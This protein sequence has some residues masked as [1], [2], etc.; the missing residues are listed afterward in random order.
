MPPRKSRKP[1]RSNRPR[2]KIM[3][4]RKLGNMKPQSQTVLYNKISDK[5]MHFV[6]TLYGAQVLTGA[7][8]AAML[9]V[10]NFRVSDIADFTNIALLFNRYKINAVHVTFTLRSVAGTAGGL[11]SSTQ[12]PK[13]FCRY[14]YDSNAVAGTVGTRMQELNNVKTM[15]FTEDE[16]VF[17]YTV[18]P[19]TVA[20]VYLSSVATGYELQKK[21]YIDSA[22]PT[23]PHY[24]IQFWIPALQ[25]G[26]EIIMDYTYD[27]TCKY[28]V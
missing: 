20:P 18:I 21:T 4:K 11:S 2:R 7:S 28:Q 26:D 8:G 23:V 19:R 25:T 6:K 22:Y 9:G 10:L 14:N 13:I 16:T 1:K 15:S 12:L 5:P 27:F 24:G 17:R 3:R